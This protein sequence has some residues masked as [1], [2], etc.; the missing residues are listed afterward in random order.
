M[1]EVALYRTMAR[2]RAFE[3][4]LGPLHE[5]GAI[6]G[7][8]H[9]CTG[10]EAVAAGV[11]GALRAEDLVT[12]THRGHG[13][14]IA[15]GLD[16]DRMMAEIAGRA[17]GYCKGRGGS[18]H[19]T[20]LADGMLGAD[21][22]VAGSVGIAVGAGYVARL[23]GE[24][25]VVASF[26][27]DGAINQGSLHEALNLAAVLAAPVVFV[28]ENNQWAMSTR[29]TDSTRVE[30]LSDRAAGY[31]MP[32]VTVDGNDVVAVAAAAAEAVERARSGAGPTLLE[33]LT[34]RIGGHSA[35]APMVY[36]GDDEVA[37]W[38]DRDPLL[39]SRRRLTGRD[40]A[41]AEELDRID[42][43]AQGEAEAAAAFAVAS[44]LPDP[45]GALDD[46][47]AP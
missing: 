45:A 40:P 12:S 1:G 4:Q 19:V 8:A 37:A 18:M 47:Y 13:H 16:M 2:I 30:R 11:C 35:N 25:R 28:C 21:G 5:Q 44:D 41:L 36:A 20:S 23:R 34:F 6:R 43:E 15:K 14:A 39:V 29:I 17:A 27:G 38:R 9:P 7:T 26:F 31:G 24:D 46:V 10:M 32:G 33:A 22:I 42:A 3:A